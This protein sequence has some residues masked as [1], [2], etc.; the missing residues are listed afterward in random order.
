MTSKN[1]ARE[2]GQFHLA[3]TT[4]VTR[5]GYGTLQLT[6]PGGWGYPK[7]PDKSMRVL[8]RAVDLGVNLI[9]TADSYGPEVAENL[10]REALYPYAE[11]L[12]IATKAGFTRPGPKRWV[13][14]GLPEY[15]RQQAEMS[16]RRL[17]VDCISLFQLHR[18]DPRVPLEV[19]VGTL[20]ELQ[21]EGKIRHIGLSE[22]DIQQLKRAQRIAR[23]DSVQNLYNLGNRV[24]DP[25]VDYT[26]RMGIGFIPWHPLATGA[27]AGHDSPLSAMAKKRNVAPSQIALAWLL[28]RSSTMLPIPGTSSI[29]HLDENV[30][31]SEISLTN[32]ELQ[33]LNGV[34]VY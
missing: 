33:I 26:E 9:D 12:V 3:G 20:K 13:P 22:V 5:L 34:R 14:V 10:I 25:L 17:N 31:A 27:L 24:A 23:I 19:Q 29:S 28:Q 15:L 11:N 16:L 18:V 7:D 6:G 4:A 8:R 21:D 30:A 1:T 2:S 32:S